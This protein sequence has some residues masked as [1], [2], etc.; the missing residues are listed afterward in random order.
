MLCDRPL[1]PFIYA[2]DFPQVA[3]EIKASQDLL[4][5]SYEARN[6]YTSDPDANPCVITECVFTGAAN[7]HQS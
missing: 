7:A 5:F 1:C 4:G 2:A 6:L 3:A